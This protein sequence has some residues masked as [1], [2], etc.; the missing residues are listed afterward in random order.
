[1]NEFG[2]DF[3]NERWDSDDIAWDMGSP[4]EPLKAYI[5]SIH[6]NEN[7]YLK[8]LI[9]G[10]GNAYEAEYLN[11]KGFRNVYIV[12]FAE[13]ALKEFS[14][15]VPGF[16][17]DHL[18][19]GDFFELKEGGFDLV[20]EQT[21]FCAIHPML[22]HAYAKKMYELLAP[23]G[24]LV[25]LLFNDPKLNFENPPFG[26]DAEMYRAIF[27]PYFTFD[28]FEAAYNSIKPRAG[29]E[30]FINLHRKDKTASDA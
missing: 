18:I 4:S 21:F 23:E 12:D 2:K 29:R 1:M 25:G 10:C 14:N 9:P 30:L 8:I 26:G 13:K 19:C 3:W 16:P 22:R 28:K 15:R 6:S 24:K 7:K 27:H 11:A 20:L 5:D 17:K